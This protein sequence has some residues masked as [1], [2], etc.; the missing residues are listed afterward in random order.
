MYRVSSCYHMIS[1]PFSQM[2]P[3]QKLKKIQRKQ[4]QQ[5]QSTSGCTSGSAD[6]MTGHS[7]QNSDKNSCGFRMTSGRVSS[8][9]L[10]DDSDSDLDSADAASYSASASLSHMQY[11]THDSPD[12]DG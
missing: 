9:R 6:V 10:S 3:Q 7:S 4:Q 5:L 8:G 2:S 11:L 1:D 12:D